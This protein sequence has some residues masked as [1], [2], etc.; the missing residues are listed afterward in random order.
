MGLLSR[1]VSLC[2]YAT[3]KWS[4]PLDLDGLLTDEELSIQQTA[5]AY[6][7]EQLFPRALLAHRNETLFDREI[8]KEMGQLGL[9]GATIKGYGCAGV[10]SNAYGLIAREVERVDSGYR[11]AMSV[12]S[13]LVMFPI[14]AYGSEA[15]KEHYLPELA[16]GRK[17]G[18]FGLTE[19]NHGSDP[20]GME[21]VAKAQQGEKEPAEYL[22]YGTKTWITNSP[23]A[24]VFVVWARCS[25]DGMVRGFILDRDME[26]LSTPSIHG[27]FSLRTSSTGMIVMDGVRVHRDRHLLP[28]VKGLKG[29][30]SCLNNARFGIAWGALGAAE[31]CLAQAR[32]YTLQR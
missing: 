17:I 25:D 23:V 31:Y 29:P 19:P 11:S 3:F 15:Q 8:L 28:G 4:N 30:F 12:Q 9:L 22:L 20:D 18:C 16:A 26:G 13:S 7:Q 2:R 21:T 24:D 27:K 32:E 1:H 6:C 14:W 5:Q 10:S